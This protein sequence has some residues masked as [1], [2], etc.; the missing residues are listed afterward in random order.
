VQRSSGRQRVLGAVVN[1]HPTL[2]RAERERLE[3]TVH[4]CRV[5]G[6]RTQL[7]DAPADGFRERL[8]GRVSWLAALDP[9]RGRRL[10]A[11]LDAVDWS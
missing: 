7:R 1:E 8:T 4:N 10:L 9:V 2:A 6:W 11:E 5:H 3:A